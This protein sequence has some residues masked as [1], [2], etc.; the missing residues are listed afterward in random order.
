MQLHWVSITLSEYKQNGH[1][2][3]LFFSSLHLSFKN[4]WKNRKLFVACW[5]F[6]Q[7]VAPHMLN[8]FVFGECE[9][10]HEE[11]KENFSFSICLVHPSSL[12]LSNSI[13]V[14]FRKYI[15]KKYLLIKMLISECYP[16]EILKCLVTALRSS[17]CHVNL[18]M[19]A[20][21]NLSPKS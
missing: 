15:L 17:S 16:W 7:I 3:T 10:F 13:P 19:R 9:P 21:K 6:Y 5:P 2:R 4:D 14:P 18:C 1:G 11:N 8:K 20:L 12:Y